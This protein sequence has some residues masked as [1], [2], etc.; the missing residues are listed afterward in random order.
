[1]PSGATRRLSVW[2][3]INL[4]TGQTEQGPHIGS[5]S[6]WRIQKKRR[7]RLLFFPLLAVLVLSAYCA[8]PRP[9]P[10]LLPSPSIPEI[11]V[12]TSANPVVLI[13]PGHGGGDS[14]AVWAG[15]NEKD[16]NLAIALQLRDILVSE[17][18]VDVV[19]T[20]DTDVHVSATRRVE[21][22]NKAKSALIVSIHVNSFELG[23]VRGVETYHRTNSAESMAVAL[24]LHEAVL[25]TYRDNV[26]VTADRDIRP[27]N[28]RI[29]SLPATQRAV[30]LE[31]GYL[32]NGEERTILS[33]SGFQTSLAENLAQAITAILIQKGP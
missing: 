30:L 10:P 33:Q 31:I 21:I 17:G 2:Q 25:K 13:D 5:C 32:S 23:Y 28:F 12:R 27:G 16:I 3:T 29:I 11:P 18:S 14:G 19:L 22:A 8:T 15:V 9:E 24:V 20:R 7:L 1:M 4:N 26:H 6:V